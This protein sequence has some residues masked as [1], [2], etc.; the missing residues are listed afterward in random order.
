MS[1]E[2]QKITITKSHQ[3][4]KIQQDR[5]GYLLPIYMKLL[6]YEIN[7]EET[8]IGKVING[9]DGQCNIN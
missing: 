7:T 9:F 4:Q 3:S 1:E 2:S 6:K 5:R 8:V